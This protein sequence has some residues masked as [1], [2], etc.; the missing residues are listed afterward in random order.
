MSEETI[1]IEPRTF[2]F[3]DICKAVCFYYRVPFVD[4][5]GPRRDG[6]FMLARHAI[7]HLASNL[8]KM[9]MCEIGRRLSR[10]QTTVRAS[11]NRSQM[12]LAGTI[13]GKIKIVER[14]FASDIK[15]LMERLEA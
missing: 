5:V 15:A 8:T 12:L 1:K 11:L 2:T 14:E 9:S 3:R 13:P 4:I 6:R 10:D 7:V